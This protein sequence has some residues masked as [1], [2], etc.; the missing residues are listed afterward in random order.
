MR[1]AGMKLSILQHNFTAM[2]WLFAGSDVF[3][4]GARG[5]D[6]FKFSIFASRLI[7]PSLLAF[8]KYWDVSNGMLVCC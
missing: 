2:V 7:Y 6:N 1:L 8:C 4:G 3:R 5:H